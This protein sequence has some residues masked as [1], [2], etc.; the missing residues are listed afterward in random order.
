M[1]SQKHKSC[2]PFYVA[3][4][5]RL[6]LLLPG[7]IPVVSLCSASR[8]ESSIPTNLPRYRTTLINE[9][10]RKIPVCLNL[11][12]PIY[13]LIIIYN[14]MMVIS[15]FRSENVSDQCFKN[16]LLHIRPHMYYLG[17]VSDNGFKNMTG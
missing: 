6:L 15:I 1:L 4:P 14:C 2:S 8:L 16:N 5:K 11:F 9:R 10:F 3:K 7:A 17:W 13:F 12:S